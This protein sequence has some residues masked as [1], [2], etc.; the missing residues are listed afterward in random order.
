VRGHGVLLL[1]VA[2]LCI[3]YLTLNG[4]PVFVDLHL[5]ASIA[6][7][8]IASLRI[9]NGWRRN[10]WCAMV[11]TLRGQHGIMALRLAQPVDGVGLDVLIRALEASAP[12]CRVVGGDTS[13]NW[14]ARLRWPEL[15]HA[16]A[17]MGPMEELQHLHAPPQTS[18]GDAGWGITCTPP[19]PLPAD[20]SRESIARHAHAACATI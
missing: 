9:W 3:S 7:L 5:A 18:A 2:L 6:L 20:A 13:A 17:I 11:P 14:P 12:L 8:F 1:P 10:Y 15:H 19:Q 16:V 4:S